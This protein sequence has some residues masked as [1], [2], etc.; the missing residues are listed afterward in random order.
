MG[1]DSNSRVYSC[2]ELNALMNSSGPNNSNSNYRQFV[3]KFEMLQNLIKKYENL[4]DQSEIYN[5]GTCKKNN[6]YPHHKNGIFLCLHCTFYGC[7]G[8]LSTQRQHFKEHNEK[9]IF[10]VNTNNLKLFCFH[11]NDYITDFHA[12]KNTEALDNVNFQM[13]LGLFKLNNFGATC[14]MNSVM[15]SLIHNPHFNNYFLST[16]HYKTCNRLNEKE[17]LTCLLVDLHALVFS[18]NLVNDK[19]MIDLLKMTLNPQ[20]GLHHVFNGYTQQDAHE[21]WQFVINKLHTEHVQSFGL[22]P[23]KKYEEFPHIDQ[24]DCISHRTFQG[25]LENSIICSNCE[26][27][28]KNYEEFVDFSVT[29]NDK[30]NSVL[31]ECLTKS[32]S[33]EIIN[34][35]KYK[36]E[37]CSF[38]NNSIGKQFKIKKFPLTLCLQLK[39]FKQMNNGTLSK[40]NKFVKF[41]EY[42]DIGRFSNDGNVSLVYELN[43][44]VVHEGTN[45]NTGHYIVFV[46]M[47]KGIWF[48]FNDNK[49]SKVN[50][51]TVLSQSAYLLFYTAN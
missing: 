34:D 39:R 18:G 8:L 14:Y 45:F 6:N 43:C 21:Y 46:N 31:T 25:I 40:I 16:E 29:I 42:I 48:K 32:F 38:E 37:S 9:H 47:G 2:S 13:Y 44:V 17:C 11:C 22:K 7:N 3:N 26:A 33:K 10:G 4:P 30:E 1:K 27:I 28:T 19:I 5:C 23:Q 36:C 12:A 35:Y 15:Q 41:D 49:F 20:L 50:L 51:E 24:C